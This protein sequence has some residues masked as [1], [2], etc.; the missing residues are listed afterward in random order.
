M[1]RR[2][3]LSGE[4]MMAGQ[5]TRRDFLTSG[6]A[7]GAGAVTSAHAQ[8][9]QPAGRPLDEFLR[10]FTADWVRRDTSLA[11]STRYFTGN[12]QDQLERQ[13]TPRT[14]AWRRAR[15]QRARQGLAELRRFDRS[16]M[17]E[18]QRV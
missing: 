17:T 15:I 5:L 16:R 8:A 12:E 18:L 11:T 3:L 6:F 1:I 7:L 9:P 2:I 14:L 10:D 13:L 4:Q